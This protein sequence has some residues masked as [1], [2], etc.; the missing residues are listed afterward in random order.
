VTAAG[1]PG[2]WL[3]VDRYLDSVVS[4]ASTMARVAGAADRPVASCPQWRVVDLLWHVTEVLSFWRQVVTDGADPASAVRS[5]RP[6]DGELAERLRLESE[7]FASG[8]R[9]ADPAAAVWTWSGPQSAAWVARRMAHETAI[10]ALDAAAASG[11]PH[12]PD[13]ELA[14]DGID[15]FLVTMLGLPREGRPRPGGSVHLHC[16]DVAGEWMVDDRDGG[17]VVTR[18]H[19]KGSCAIRGGSAAILAVLWRRSTPATVEVI[20]DGDVAARFVELADLS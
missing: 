19:A 8:M 9:A 11:A 1:V 10:H 13:A 15:E 2:H 5:A 16:T 14:A 7:R 17:F 3:P 4:A 6:G 20:G 12:V 18:E